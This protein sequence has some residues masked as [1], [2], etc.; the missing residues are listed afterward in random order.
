MSRRS[1]A[2][3][4]S[5]TSGSRHNLTNQQSQS[6]GDKLRGRTN[7]VRHPKPTHQG[8]L[9]DY[10]I[11]K[12]RCENTSSSR[13]LKFEDRKISA[14]KAQDTSIG[15]I[16]SE[17]E[18]SQSLL[19]IFE[20]ELATAKGSSEKP[21]LDELPLA[22]DGENSQRNPLF[23]DKSA[24]H[25]LHAQQLTPDLKRDPLCLAEMLSNQGDICRPI[26]QAVDDIEKVLL[27][28][29]KPAGTPE[30]NR[31]FRIICEALQLGLLAAL[32]SL[33]ACMQNISDTVQETLV[34]S[35][36]GDLQKLLTAIRCSARKPP[37]HFSS[38]LE[39][40]KDSK[41]Q[42][43][44]Q[45]SSTPG[46]SMV[47]VIGQRERIT[48][49]FC[50]STHSRLSDP[51]DC[52]EVHNSIDGSANSSSVRPMPFRPRN[53]EQLVAKIA[54]ETAGDIVTSNLQNN[55]EAGGG[56]D[57]N[58]FWHTQEVH[59][60]SPGTLF[61]VSGPSH[62]T[63][64]ITNEG[65]S[66][67]YKESDISHMD[68]PLGLSCE[69]IS[70]HPRFPP[71][72]TMEPLI[73]YNEADLSNSHCISDENRELS[74]S[75]ASR[76]RGG[77][78]IRATGPV[79][80]EEPGVINAPPSPVRATESSGQ[81]F[82][83][84]TGRGREHS[85]LRDQYPACIDGIRRNA[86]IAGRRKNDGSSN[87]RPYTIHSSGNTRI[88][89][90]SVPQ[91]PETP[92][93]GLERLQTE[94]FDTR[95][96]ATTG[97]GTCMNHSQ[98]SGMLADMAYAVDHSDAATAGKIQE[99]V[100]QLQFLGFHHN[101]PDGLRRLVVYAQAA[102]GELSNAIDMIDEEQKAYNQRQ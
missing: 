75:T 7:R 5:A 8:L 25:K 44:N 77:P 10:G 88:P 12:A 65:P 55:P 64:K 91:R 36:S 83:R 93:R 4:I 16:E 79:A 14:N 90:S 89:W 95:P 54:R 101:T 3:Q 71:L 96:E 15:R 69:T 68:G 58:V 17:N 78:S 39:L 80:S 57:T 29:Q 50:L 46:T 49:K 23:T 13:S 52:L 102:E 72:P 43:H 62:K 99:C 30:E 92:P 100:E 67:L 2:G 70:K 51:S 97:E 63:S 48:P 98:S 24:N 94:E 9:T 85:I 34:D 74:S 56:Q 45:G 86:T 35:S 81:F 1:D 84:M 31:S 40:S 76:D 33:G 20:S 53:R 41:S 38:D 61:S 32:Q 87:Y 60:G 21:T 82:N 73:P 27:E 28:L 66:I 6:A 47:T 37:V 18:T 42:H 26:H 22:Q 11:T 59:G 19:Q